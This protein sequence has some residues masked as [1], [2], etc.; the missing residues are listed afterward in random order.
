MTLP[1]P[2][3]R[4]GALETSVRP[5]RVESDRGLKRVFPLSE[6]GSTKTSSSVLRRIASR[7]FDTNRSSV[8][9]NLARPDAMTRRQIL[10]RMLAG[11]A[12]ETPLGALGKLKGDALTGAALQAA[13]V[14]Q[15]VKASPAINRRQFLR[16]LPVVAA[17]QVSAAG[18]ALNAV[19]GVMHFSP[20]A[21]ALKAVAPAKPG[22][23]L[24]RAAGVSELRRGARAATAAKEL[25][26]DPTAGTIRN[27]TRIAIGAPETS[28]RVARSILTI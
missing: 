21:G 26:D 1:C 23:V 22:A 19:E 24:A 16:G 5:F 9:G 25:V 8:V 2:L 7:V 4:S 3:L 27:I 12:A 10:Q 18:K 11:A 17:G 20:G 14:Q 15:A 13:A 28:L 6:D